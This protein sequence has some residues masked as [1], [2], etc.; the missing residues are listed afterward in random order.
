[1]I[2]K[3]AESIGDPNPLWQ[4]EEYAR[5]TKY[6]GITAPPQIFCTAMLSGS[7]TFP[8]VPF[9]FKRM[10]DGGGEWEF[11][12]PL[13]P[14]DV[15]TST[16]KFANV[17][18]REGKLGIMVFMVFETTHKNQRGEIVAKSRGTLISY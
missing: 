10:L 8:E 2:K 14:G 11:F 7:S 6:G 18:E 4:D 15:I 13:R 9:P 1:M 5:K 3:F 12:L 16:T 17:S